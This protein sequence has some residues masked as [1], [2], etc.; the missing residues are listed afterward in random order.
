MDEFQL[1]YRGLVAGDAFGQALLAHLDEGEGGGD[2]IVE[3][4]DGFAEANRA[5]MYFASAAVWSLAEA[6]GLGYATG[7]V[8]D[9]GAGAGR[10][11]LWLQRRGHPV[12]ALDVSPGVLE[13]CRRRGVAETFL[14]TVADLAETDPEPFDS[15]VLMGNNLGLLES[16][17]AAGAFLRTLARLGRP[18]AIIVGQGRDPY[19]TDNPDHLRYHQHNRDRGRMAGQVR[20]RIR[21]RNMATAWFDYLFTSLDELE[22]IAKSAGWSIAERREEDAGY[23]VVLRLGPG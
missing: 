2:H 1:D 4:D 3:R 16:A 9:V 5:E 20:L 18:G 11:S 13:V 19:R 14:G 12:V 23:V 17:D 10:H 8:L 22:A 21:W 15:F 7:R 6:D